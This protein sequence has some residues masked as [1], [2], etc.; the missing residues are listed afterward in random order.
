MDLDYQ[1]DFLQNL[2]KK[3]GE[4]L[5]K[6]FVSH[7]FTEKQIDSINFTTQVDLE[8]GNLLV[9][10]LKLQFPGSSILM[11]E[12]APM[13]YSH[14]K[15]SDKL[16]IIDPVDGTTNFSRDNPNFGIS[17]A[18]SHKSKI[19]L[20]VVYLPIY[21][22]LFFARYDKNFAFLNGKRIK[23]SSISDLK[24][25]IVA[26]DWPWQLANRK[27]LLRLVRKLLVYV[28]QIRSLSSAVLNLTSLAEGKIDAYICSGIKP[29]DDAACALII[30]KAGGLITQP[31]GKNWTPF[32]TDILASNSILHEKLLSLF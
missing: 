17:V 14:L 10:N 30:E 19:L 11:E 7:R 25:A 22:K 6:R 23:T 1:S 18:L 29:W 21:E 13:S 2:V 27:K 5:K 3:A 20:G 31:D 32:E 16:W 24:K 26:C 8:I 12:T 4:I 9:S 15:N 28:R